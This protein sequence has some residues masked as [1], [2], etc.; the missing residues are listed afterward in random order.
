M[1]HRTF[2]AT[3]LSLVALAAVAF[4]VEAYPADMMLRYPW[5]WELHL[6]TQWMLALLFLKGGF[7]AFILSWL[8]QA[9]FGV[10]RKDKPLSARKVQFLK[11]DFNTRIQQLEAE[12]AQ[13]KAFNETLEAALEKAR[14]AATLPP[15]PDA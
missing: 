11:D 3:F 15:E 13:L 7:S 1:F 12:K 9:V 6:D 10:F 2:Y 5:G 8:Y 4:V 14:T